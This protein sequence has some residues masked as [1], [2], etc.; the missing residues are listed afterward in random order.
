M[1]TFT[2][3]QHL[4]IFGALLDRPYNAILAR[5]L[6]FPDYIL[7]CLNFRGWKSAVIC[8]LDE[9]LDTDQPKAS[10][11]FEQLARVWE[12]RLTVPWDPQAIQA[13]LA[14]ERKASLRESK[15]QSHRV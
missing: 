9:D 7:K 13:D 3:L 14:A 4:T 1:P 15:V 6:L 8:V 5:M 11:D 2:G 10:K 12:K